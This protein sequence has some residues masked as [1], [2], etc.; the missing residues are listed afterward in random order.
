MRKLLW[1]SAYWFIPQS[2]D[3]LISDEEKKQLQSKVLSAAESVSEIYKDLVIADA[4]NYS[5]VSVS[6]LANRE[7][8]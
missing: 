6:F 8:S 7:R 2:S 5:S 4:A 3:C 1:E